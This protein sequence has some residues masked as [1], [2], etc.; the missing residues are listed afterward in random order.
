MNVRDSADVV[1]NVKKMTE[2]SHLS[3][4]DEHICAFQL[5]SLLR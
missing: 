1:F 5:V 2:M 4:R 3:H